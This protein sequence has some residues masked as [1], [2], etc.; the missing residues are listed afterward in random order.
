VLD[1]PLALPPG[2]AENEMMKPAYRSG[3][4]YERARQTYLLFQGAASTEDF[5]LDCHFP[6]IYTEGEER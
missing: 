2:V 6:E 3:P 4:L 1:R 5:T